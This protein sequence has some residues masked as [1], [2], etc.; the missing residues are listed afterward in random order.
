MHNLDDAYKALKRAESIKEKNYALTKEAK[1]LPLILWQLEKA[2]RYAWQASGETR[3]PSV[4]LALEALHKNKKDSEV[5]FQRKETFVLWI[6]GKKTR[7][8]DEK[9][10]EVFMKKT[11]NYLQKC[12]TKTQQKKNS[13][14]LI[15]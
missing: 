14:V 5:E 15:I 4:L 9:T 2:V 8:I 12:T 6:Q 3:K 10:V 7:V 11:Q 13:S 1:L